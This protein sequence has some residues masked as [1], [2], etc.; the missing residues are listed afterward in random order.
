MPLKNLQKNYFRQAQSCFFRWED[1]GG[2]LAWYDGTTIAFR[3]E[4]SAIMQRLAGETLPPMNAIAV[5]LSACRDNWEQ[6][7]DYLRVFTAECREELVDLHQQDPAGIRAAQF[8]FFLKQLDRIHAMPADLRADLQARTELAA[9]ILDNCRK[10]PDWL[11]CEQAGDVAEQMARG[12]PA[13]LQSQG[14]RNP[15]QLGLELHGRTVPIGCTGL[16][17]LNTEK[18]LK[19]YARWLLQDL[20]WLREGLPLVTE[21]A[22]RRRLKT[23]LEDPVKPLQRPAVDVPHSLI[24]DL[25]NDEELG[26]LARLARDLQA[27]LTFPRQPS[28]PE[29]LPLGGVSD[30]T[31]RGQL[32]RLLLSE[33]AHDDLT[34]ST[35]IAVNEALYL[36]RESPPATKSLCRRVLLDTG[37]CL[38]GIPRLFVAAVGL[39]LAEANQDDL[40]AE[41]HWFD[42]ER[43]EAVD[44][45][46]RAGLEDHLS[47]LS[48][49]L[50][51]GRSLSEFF[52]IDRAEETEFVIVTHADVALDHEF[53]TGL[54]ELL[55]DEPTFLIAV[56]GSGQ[57]TVSVVHRHGLREIRK[58]KL[59]L[60]QLLQSP[61]KR[62]LPV[63]GESDLPI[64]LR[65]KEFPLRMYHQVDPDRAFRTTRGVIAC[66]GDGRLMLWDEHGLGARQLSDR[67]GHGQ[68]FWFGED[69]YGVPLIVHG[70]LLPSSLKIIR[71]HS[72]GYISQTH[73]TYDDTAV[74]VTGH[75]GYVMVEFKDRWELFRSG[76]AECIA[77]RM[78]T[79][80]FAGHQSTVCSPGMSATSRFLYVRNDAGT[81]GCWYALAE[82]DA[83]IQLHMVPVPEPSEVESLFERRGKGI[84]AIDHNGEMQRLYGGEEHSLVG[85]GGDWCLACT[86]FDGR[87]A[88]ITNR[89]TRR[90]RMIVTDTFEQHD[91]K[92]NPYAAI[93]LFDACTV[94]SLRKRFTR[95]G[96]AED[97][98]FLRS[99]KGTV[100]EI[101]AGVG[102][103]LVQRAQA[104][105]IQETS[106]QEVS[107]PAGCAYKLQVAE[108]DCGS[109]AWLDSRG[110]LHLVSCHSDVPQ[111]SLVLHEGR[112]SGWCETGGV[113][114]LG[115]CSPGGTET[116]IENDRDVFARAVEGFMRCLDI[117]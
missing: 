8:E 80:V 7:R 37:V 57:L 33:L 48:T 31:N 52:A 97:R 66:N 112:M 82:S 51:P 56:D 22:W 72:D 85:G 53:R 96:V 65:Q 24:G 105:A 59:Q 74:A 94:H 64:I 39:S 13:E 43:L 62:R 14:Q 45:G 18:T 77:R 99:P 114:G 55:P 111:I 83:Q 21:E 10:N 103:R 6:A 63:S 20:Q 76:H 73:L 26:D 25:L 100:L 86:T 107:A 12:L 60:D 50:H 34:L 28:Q 117:Q 44:L 87:C 81:G 109:R 108:W 91:V 3:P 41:F 17:P 61:R 92:G 30:I 70:S 32:D 93:S 19:H 27:L 106:F 16:S 4:L 75:N 9:M 29:D 90:F 79:D 40:S 2:V 49:S 104:P 84:V 47:R 115:Y 15:G 35:R 67:I 78:K 11:T 42:G 98:M 69:P 116:S 101:K 54:C 5:L 38:W 36:H 23:G 88:V 71:V 46:S 68:V 89:F 102:I 113:F 1:E 58:G 95:I 110:L